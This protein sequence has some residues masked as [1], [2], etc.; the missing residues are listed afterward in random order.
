MGARVNGLIARVLVAVMGAALCSAAAAN[1]YQDCAGPLRQ[2]DG[3][4][5][6]RCLQPLAEAGDPQA[7]KL[8]G[9]VYGTVNDPIYD[10][11]KSAIWVRR[12]AEHGDLEAQGWVGGLY[13]DGK[14]VPKDLAEAV[15][16]YRIA[17]DRGDQRAQF[18]LGRMYFK[19]I[20]TPRD[21]G[22][23]ISWERKAADQAGPLRM[24]AEVSIAG[25]Y[26][27]GDG[28]PQDYAEA[29]RWFRRAGEHGNPSAYLSLAAMD[30]KGLGGPPDPFEAY[31]GYSIG[32]AWLQNLHYPA[33]VTDRIVRHRDDVA[34]KLTA[35]QKAKADRFVREHKGWAQ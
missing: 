24:M 14:G 17:A 20:G 21:V 5:A 2:L 30:E 16:W 18:E 28:V 6:I 33:Q 27:V 25:I 35:A 4:A 31:V 9:V 29:A 34:A 1:P 11:E 26:L 8:L 3:A 7:E 32:L 22:Q 23:A 13:E 12:A 10:P 19:G 15:R